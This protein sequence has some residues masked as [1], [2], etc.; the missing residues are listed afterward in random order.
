MLKMI[1]PV[2]KIMILLKRWRGQ[3]FFTIVQ[4]HKQP[5]SPVSQNTIVR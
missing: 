3:L 5:F 2:V 1:E 4:L